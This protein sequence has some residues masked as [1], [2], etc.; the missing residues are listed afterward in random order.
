ML[1]LTLLEGD[2]SALVVIRR[3]EVLDRMIERELLNGRPRGDVLLNL[4][5]EHI[6][7][8]GGD[9]TTFL[10]VEVDVVGETFDVL[11]SRSGTPVNPYFYV[12]MMH[13]YERQRTLRT[14]TKEE[15][16]RVKERARGNTWVCTLSTL[17]NILSEGIHGYIF[18]ENRILSVD[19]SSAD[20]KFDFIDDT[21]PVLCIEGFGGIIHGEID[22]TE[23]ITTPLELDARHRIVFHRS[24]DGLFFNGL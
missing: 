9:L 6:V 1:N 4:C 11:T 21:A 14:L 10:I 18:R 13:S 7:R 5:H 8:A 22:I 23:K 16:Q 19:D 20:Q 3:C 24:V 12:V 15:T 2:V 17:G